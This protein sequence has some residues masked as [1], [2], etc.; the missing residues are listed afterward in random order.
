MRCHATQKEPAIS[1]AFDQRLKHIL[2]P[3]A[4]SILQQLDHMLDRSIT[5]HTHKH[6]Y[7][8]LDHVLYPAVRVGLHDRLHP[9]ER[10]HV[11]RES[12]G[13]Q[14]ELSVWGNERD[15]PIVLESCEPHTP[16]L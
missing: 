6:T 1:S 9:D 15:R 5:D 14:I 4:A 11:R 3:S 13:H 8:H 12:V 7:T 10:L 16:S 2:E